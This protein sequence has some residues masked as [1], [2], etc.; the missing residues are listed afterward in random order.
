MEDEE[1]GMVVSMVV[2][3]VVVVVRSMGRVMVVDLQESSLAQSVVH[4]VWGH[5][6]QIVCTGVTYWEQ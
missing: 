1:G 3:M 5:S 4:W 6:D 2:A